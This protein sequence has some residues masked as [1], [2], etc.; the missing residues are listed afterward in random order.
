[1]GFI[2]AEFNKLVTPRIKK[3]EISK[4]GFPIKSIPLTPLPLEKEGGRRK[5]GASPLLN[6]P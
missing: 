6:T 4:N 5:E 1:M 3:G 2:I